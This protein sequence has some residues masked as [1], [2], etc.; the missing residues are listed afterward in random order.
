MGPHVGCCVRDRQD[1]YD[2]D[3]LGSKLCTKKDLEKL[4][5]MENHYVQEKYGDILKSESGV[6]ASLIV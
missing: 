1:L 2:L 6:N 4:P 3:R 5:D